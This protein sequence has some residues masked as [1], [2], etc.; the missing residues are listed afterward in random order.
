MNEQMP[1][2]GSPFIDEDDILVYGW[3][4]DGG[5]GRADQAAA[6]LGLPQERAAAALKRLASLGLV[7]SVRDAPDEVVVVDPDAVTAALT[8]PLRASIRH[9]EEQLDLVHGKID[10]LRDHF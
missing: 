9:Q 7:R 8:A 4:V 5:S 10:R 3:I 6:E 2:P 1:S